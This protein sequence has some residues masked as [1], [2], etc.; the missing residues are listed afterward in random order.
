MILDRARG[1]AFND[2]DVA[3]C[4]AHR[5]PYAPELYERLFALAP[6]R[7][8]ALD[9][10]CGPGKIALV[11]ANRFTAVD[12]VDPSGPLLQAGQVS[13]EG[14]HSNIRWLQSTS[15]A[16]NLVGPYDLVTAGA[17]LH[18]MRHEVVFPR[19]AAGLSQGGVMAV[20]AGDGANDAP[21]EGEW[22]AFLTDWIA[23]MGG[24]Y[25][26]AGFGQAM[27]AYAPWMDVQGRETFSYAHEQLIEDFIACQHSR[28]TWARARMGTE[29]AREFDD[30]LRRLLVPHTQGGLLRFSVTSALV[31]GRPRAEPHGA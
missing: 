14:R 3:A 10:G 5:A 20:I 4:Y 24:R 26:K 22:G 6:G 28:E 17:S 13:D 12:A 31:W 21:W 19:L 18:W 25:D 23:R 15:E 2:A 8:R 30:D 7:E 29:L 1:A 11:L 27:N 9:L 16:A